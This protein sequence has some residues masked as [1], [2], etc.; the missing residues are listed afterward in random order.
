MSELPKGWVI[1]NLG[2]VCSKPQYGYTTK[3]D[4]GRDRERFITKIKS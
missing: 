2:E 3:A 1:T 4:P